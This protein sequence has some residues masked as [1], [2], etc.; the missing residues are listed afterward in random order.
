MLNDGSTCCCLL[1]LFPLNI[2]TVMTANG[3]TWRAR[4]L[5][6]ICA[7][8]VLYCWVEERY[9][10]LALPGGNSCPGLR[11]RSLFGTMIYSEVYLLFSTAALRA[12]INI[13][14]LRLGCHSHPPVP[15]GWRSSPRL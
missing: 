15:Q 10:H 1:P 5:G 2:S 11:V 7:L 14:S 4:C 6:I 3:L 9:D 8:L 13:R 12:L